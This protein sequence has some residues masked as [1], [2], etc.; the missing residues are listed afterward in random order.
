MPSSNIRK[1]KAEATADIVIDFVNSYGHDAE[2][3]A[4]RIAKAHRTLQQSVMRLIVATIQELANSQYDERNA[5]TVR[6]AMEIMKIAEGISLPL[7]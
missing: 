7:I 6:L 5:A 3:F 2:S 1:M 4:K